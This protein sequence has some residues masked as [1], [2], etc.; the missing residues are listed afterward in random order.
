MRVLFSSTRGTGHLQPL[1]PYARALLGHGHEVLVA[2]PAEL[3][4]PLREER[5]PHAP[6]GHPGED[7][8]SPIWARLHGVSNDDALAIGAR[9]IFAGANATAALPQLQQTIRDWKPDLIV[10]DSVEFAALVAAE[11]AGVP[12]ARVAVHLVSF[13]EQLPPLVVPPLDKLRAHLGLPP[14]EGASL[15]SEPV[16][17][18]FP[19]S[20]DGPGPSQM[21]PP[22]RCRE[23]GQ[24]PSSAAPTWRSADDGRPL[25]Y[26][27][28]G[29]IAGST[30][31]ARAAYRTA[32]DAVAE[33]PVRALLTTGRGLPADA[34]GA[35]PANVQ[36]EA[37]VAQREVLPQA[38]A[39]VCHAGSG[40]VLGALAAG[41]PMVA[42]PLFADQPHNARRIEA[43]GAGLALSAPDASTLRAA[44]VRVL[45]EP[46]FRSAARRMAGEIAA[47]PTVD[48]AVDVLAGLAAS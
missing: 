32:L 40:T 45:A 47:L 2:G 11:L 9:D 7:A 38:S 29:T 27:T 39:V 23:I 17:S 3:S 19:A 46:E 12:H 48:D 13:E 44:L 16:F 15:C 36:V 1:L 43:V 25:V 5:L 34:L 8:L 28:F 35:I 6:F 4:T 20:M 26:L 31:Y 37:W 24:E 18:C 42:T 21:R 10:R 14:D 33:L 30:A 41:V 22:F